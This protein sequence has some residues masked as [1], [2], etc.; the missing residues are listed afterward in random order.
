MEKLSGF[1]TESPFELSNSAAYAVW[2][3]KKLAAGK[4]ALAAGFIEIADPKNMRDSEVEAIL[5]RCRDTNIASIPR[6]LSL[7]I[8]YCVVIYGQ[9]R[10]GWVWANRRGIAPRA[11]R[12]LLR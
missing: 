8:R 4:R 10:K 2:R 1:T 6:P 9:W 11:K 5:S 12:P 3:E 7:T